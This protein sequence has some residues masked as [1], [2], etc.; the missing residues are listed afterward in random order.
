MGYNFHVSQVAVAESATGGQV[1]VAVTITQV[2]VAPFYFPLALELDCPGLASGKS[3]DGVEALIDEGDAS[4]FQFTGIPATAQCLEA[5]S[6]S[7]ASPNLYAER[8]VKFAQGD[9][10][11]TLT[12]PLSDGTTLPPSPVQAPTSPPTQAPAQAQT[13]PPTQAPVQAQTQAPIGGGNAITGFTLMDASGTIDTAIVNLVDGAT[14][15]L[16]VVG[17]SLSIRAD[18]SGDVD[19]VTFDWNGGSRSEGA[20]PWA[21]GG[22][23]GDNY[24]PVPYLATIGTKAVTVKAYSSTGTEV[25]SNTL[26]F[27]VVNGSPPGPAMTSAPVAAPTKAPTRQPTGAPVAASTKAP[28]RQPTGAPVASP[29]GVP[30]ASPTTAGVI[31]GFSLVN[32]ASDTV[33]G[34]LSDGDTVTLG[35]VGNSLNVDAETNGESNI[36]EVEFYFDSSYARTEGVPPYALGGNA[37][38]N[39]FNYSPL[40]AAGSH[41]ISAIALGKN[42]A[43]LGSLSVS[44]TVVD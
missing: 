6:L 8:P 33:L 20:A 19:D 11:V 31:I 18:T 13:S 28:T 10:S 2:G 3:L 41:V 1:D 9:G 34:P 43:V 30:N 16:T 37:G 40:A 24:Y 21:M 4:V 39:Y 25:G 23:N 38:S 27:M 35:V 22:N 36:M 14:V 32:S 12:L 15:D 7:L 5:V 44:I 26:I 29:T 17:N 42:S